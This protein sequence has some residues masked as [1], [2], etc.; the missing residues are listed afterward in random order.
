MPEKKAKDKKSKPPMLPAA[1]PSDTLSFVWGCGWKNTAIFGLGV[2]GGV[3][4]G[5]VYPLLAYL[6][7]GSFVDISAATEG[8]DAMKNIREL[9]YKFMAIGVYALI[10]AACQTFFLEISARNACQS[11]RLQ[12]FQALLRQDSAFYDVNDVSGI[13]SSLGPSAIKYQRGVGRKFGD[14]LQFCVTGV[15]GL[16]FGFYS[17]WRVALLVCAFLP[18]VSFVAL[19]VVTLN[20]TKS[21][22]GAKYYGK[23]ANVAYTTVS[24]IRT[25]FALNAIPEMIRQYTD[26]TQDAFDQA[27]KSVFKEG[28]ANGGMLGSFMI[29]Y[30]LLVLYGS[31]L[32]YKDIESSG[33]DPSGGV[34]GNFTCESSGSAV[35]GAML[36]IMFAAQGASQV[37]NCTE[38]FA[39]ARTAAAAALLAINRVPGTPEEVVYKTEEELE[40][41]KESSTSVATTGDEES[42]DK[43]NVLDHTVKAVL[44]KYEIDSFSEGGLKPENIKGNLEFKDVKFSYPTRPNDPILRGLSVNIPA[45]KSIALVGPSG[46]GKSTIVSMLE[47]FYD[48]IS[49]SVELDGTNIKDLNVSYLRSLIGY[50]GQEPTLFATSIKANIQYGKPGATQEEIEAA[51]RMANAHD[52]IMSFPN[53]YDTQVGDKGSQLSGGQKQR[54][55]ISRVLVGE[56]KLLLLD[57]ATS[58]LDSESELVVQDAL[59]NV[60]SHRSLTTVIIA[61]RLSTIRSADMIA[62]I[63]K[64]TIV[65]TGTHDELLAAETGYYRNLVEK[66]EGGGDR[67]SMNSSRNSSS[68]SLA[69]M[70]EEG[71]VDPGKLSSMS[72]VPHLEFKNVTFA[73][74]TRPNKNIF[75][76]FNLSINRGETVAL[77]GPS[78]GGK[79]TTVAMIERFYDPASGSLE[80]MG[81]D[82]KSLNVHWFREQIGYVGQEPTLFNETIAKNIA[83][84]APNATQ[85]EIEDAAKQANA[86]MFINEF[87]NGYQTSVGERG[88]QLSG[89]QKQRVAIARALVKKP[90]V[91]ILDEATSAL[92]SESEAI[93]QAALDELMA[94]RDHTTLV[95][96]HRLSTIASA[97]K[98]AFIADGK[99]LE[100]GTPSELLAKKHGRYKR[101]VES[102]KRGATL[103][104]LLAKQKKDD[105]EDAEEDAEEEIE[106]AKKEEEEEEVQAF[107]SKRARELASPDI[108]YMLLGSIGAIMAGG[109]F[110]LWGILFAQ[111]I[112]LLFRRVQV[113]QDDMQAEVLGFATC[114]DYWTAFADS[115][116]ERSFEVGAMWA[117]LMVNCMVGFTVMFAGFG[118]ASERL[119]KRVRNDAFTSLIRQEIGFFDKRSVGQ[120]TSELQDDAARIHSFSGVPIRSALVALASVVTGLVLSFIYMW[121]F[122]LLALACVPLMAFGSSMEMKKVLGEDVKVDGKDELNSPGGIVI[123]TL[124]NMRTVSAL[125]LEKQ[126]FENYKEALL[127]SDP[128]Y[129]WTSF[130][131]GFVSGLSMF[132][133]QWVNALQFWW[134]GYLLVNYPS[135]FILEDFLIS[136]FALLFGMFGLGSAFQDLADSKEVEKSVGRIFY[137]MDRKSSIDPLSNEGKILDASYER[138]SFDAYNNS[139]KNEKESDSTHKK[140]QPSAT[141]LASTPQSKFP[142]LNI[143]DEIDV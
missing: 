23:A 9:A 98:I 106:E 117:A 1:S 79:S 127:K 68:S 57:E 125:T 33:C 141:A 129:L 88:G 96:A 66:Q 30:C 43:K 142:A 42:D 32:L 63:V 116:Q 86:H 135:H 45:G 93:V 51:A 12:W 21:A 82:L 17:S 11:M 60:L 65:E 8:G 22:R 100:Y 77:V 54:I 20:Q 97:D 134:G 50:V 2:T 113:C 104:S 39:E 31:S 25:V 5:L 87:A 13:A 108:S 52:F 70:G 130:N 37:G 72:G 143:T 78:G 132:I 102:Q 105:T 107:D 85:A 56:P 62:V 16:I 76:D 118:R 122:A 74:P 80:Y 46:G 75:D 34:T 136:N 84:G 14:G 69:K 26:A 128:N 111:T 90:K 110:P 114:E 64:G 139:A 71:K 28:L 89:G 55:A 38:A 49:G 44:P 137:I 101:L 27:V 10:A 123:E 73:Y 6:F 4:N 109:V 95:I 126:R 103:E 138:P 120:I 36:G 94:S 35:F 119:S 19:Q 29:L 83:Y 115:M 92:D 47:R 41:E 91:L 24:A 140:R 40:D 112:D 131:S 7:S 18:V 121:P 48:P 81:T 61:H 15:G 3:A 53:G 67:S 124:L 58:A 99:V 133:Q 59:D